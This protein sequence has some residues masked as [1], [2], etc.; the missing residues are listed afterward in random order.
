MA[1]V[2]ELTERFVKEEEDLMGSCFSM[3]KFKGFTSMDSKEFELLKNTIK[4]MDTVNE[5]MVAYAEVIN[6]MN[7]KLD[8]IVS[9]K[10]KQA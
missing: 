10:D 4:I 8:R 1:N 5:L 2:K 7:T 9:E 3:M 6:D